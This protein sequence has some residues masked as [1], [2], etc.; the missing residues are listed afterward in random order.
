MSLD[1]SAYPHLDTATAAMLSRPPAERLAWFQTEWWIDYPLAT[2]ILETLEALRAKPRRQRM[3]GHVIAAESNN[4]KSMIAKRFADSHPPKFIDDELGPRTQISVIFLELMPE[5][6]QAAILDELL[7]AVGAP[8]RPKD[9]PQEKRRVLIEALR[10]A[11]L[12]VLVID[13]L[14]R[15]LGAKQDQR[16]VILDLLRYIANQVPVPLAVFSTPRGSG[17]LAM[18]DE[19]INRL[20]PMPLPRWKLDP[21]FQRLLASFE[22]RMPLTKPSNLKGREMATLIHEL[23]EGLIGEVYGLLEMALQSALGKQADSITLELLRSLSWVKPAERKR[24]AK[25]QTQ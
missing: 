18:S 24:E 7:E 12:R 23:T 4:G 8:Y 11:D 6:S 21:D 10:D 15:L 19:T 5:P 17:A 16:R 25:A 2:E 20:R 22:L 13:E 3:A 9:S 1:V 14:Q